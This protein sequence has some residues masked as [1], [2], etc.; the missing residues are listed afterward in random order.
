MQKV[1]ISMHSSTFQNHIWPWK[2][3][4]VE[5]SILA[6]TI[7][8]L[9]F[10]W[11]YLVIYLNGTYELHVFCQPQAQ[12]WL[13]FGITKCLDHKQELKNLIVIKKRISLLK[14]RTVIIKGIGNP[15]CVI[16]NINGES[17]HL[18]WILPFIQNGEIV[19]TCHSE[20]N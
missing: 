18:Q 16:S 4:A 9:D 2:R 5:H 7:L 8:Q 14:S 11:I 12:Q 3:E 1:A 17:F 6:F 15:S 19:G 13:F 10:P 20:L